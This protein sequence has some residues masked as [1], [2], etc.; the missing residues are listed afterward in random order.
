MKNYRRLGMLFM[1]IGMML[2]S[3]K[4]IAQSSFY[5]VNVGDVKVTSLSDGSVDIDV[6]QLFDSK[7]GVKASDL[8]KNAYLVN[9]VEV[10]INAYLVQYDNKNILIDTGAGQIFGDHAGKLVNTLK[11]YGVKPEEITDIL[12]THI[13]VDHIGGLV[14][15]NQI[16]Y[17]NAT[18]HV[19]EIEYNYWMK[20]MNSDK[21][22]SGLAKE[23]QK[24]VENVQKVVTV[25]ANSKQIQTFKNNNG[26][27]LSL[28][29]VLPTVG[30]TPGHT[31]F[32]LSSNGHSMYFWGDL[33]H[34]ASVQFEEPFMI[35][36]FDE[37]IELA[38]RVRSAF[39]DKM[40]EGEYL[41]GGAHQSFPG[42][43]RM[44]KVGKR[45]QW[46]SVPYSVTGR[47]K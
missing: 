15:D 43:G 45:Y 47:T 9:P 19:N 20:T 29:E 39:Y 40:V 25:Y 34:V 17:P 46:I 12:I 18:I 3:T 10:S 31:V 44:R 22:R 5:S 37:D 24:I 36:H 16:V 7:E 13:H 8:I 26:E 33:V 32:V 1:G 14:V 28:I 42:F 38:K 11:Q 23:Q 41:I 27:L 6:D 4:S 2:L 21:A 30:H 35:N